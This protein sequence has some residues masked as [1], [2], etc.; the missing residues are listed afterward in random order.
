MRLCAPASFFDN[1]ESAATHKAR[2]GPKIVSLDIR[3]DPVEDHSGVALL[4]VR[5]WL[6]DS[7]HDCDYL[8]PNLA[9]PISVELRSAACRRCLP[10]GPKIA[11]DA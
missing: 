6:A 5:M 9:N 11:D 10:Q 2:V 1:F 7:R 3:P 8:A 4:A